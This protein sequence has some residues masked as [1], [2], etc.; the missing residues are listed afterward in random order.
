M[1]EQIEASHEAHERLRRIASQVP[2][3]LYQFLRRIDGSSC[4]PYCSEGIRDI[5]GVDPEDVIDDAQSAF[6]VIHLN[7][8]ERVNHSIEESA[9]RLTPWELEYRVRLPDSRERWVSGQAI[10]QRLEDGSTLWHGFITDVTERIE[11][12]RQMRLLSA[13]VDSAENT[14][15]ITDTR[16]RL[17]WANKAFTRLTGYGLDEAISSTDN[18]LYPVQQD[19]DFYRELWNTINRGQVW[20]GQLVNRRR[21]GS[22]Y[23]EHMTITPVR[24][25]E[26]CVANFIAVK[27]DVTKQN[28][29][30][31]ELNRLALHDGLTG[32]PNR[33]RFRNKL[34]QAIERVQ[35]EP[36]F[37]FTMLFFNLDRFKIIN[38]SL[39]HEAGDK[40]LIEMSR[41]LTGKLRNQ[42]IV[43]R[44]GGDEFAMLLH[45][46][47]DLSN[48]EA[49]ARRVVRDVA[50]PV[51][52]DGQMIS[53]SVSIG[54]VFIEDG[55]RNASQILRD[56][57]TAMYHAKSS[58]RHCV[59]TFDH[60]MRDEVVRRHFLENELRAE[61]WDEEF[62]LHYQ[63]V[64]G[65][66][67][68]CLEGFEALVR[69]T[70]AS[71]PPVSP[72]VFIPIAEE[73]GVI[74][75]LGDW[76]FRQACRQLRHWLDTT[77]EGMQLNMKVNFSRCQFGDPDLI[78][79]V[80][81]VLPEERV[82]PSFLTLE[83]TESVMLDERLDAAPIL[84][85]LRQLGVMIALDD[86]G[87]GYSSLSCLSNLP[88]DILKIDRS[89]V[90]DMSTNR[91]LIAIVQAIIALTDCLN[92]QVIA[93]GVESDDHVM[94]L[95]TLGCTYAQGYYFGRPSPTDQ[96][97]EYLRKMID[98]GNITRRAKLLSG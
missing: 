57:D 81:R 7:D 1:H 97:T 38:D 89:F 55:S 50:E 82:P 26:G 12:D 94:M 22:A 28:K 73:I 71:G 34:E 70:P 63:P 72:D 85:R 11:A 46:V 67:D 27:E 37:R 24:N 54:L 48:A 75:S 33:T 30:R 19:G 76:V 14:I 95:Q 90:M 83:V 32:L 23:D 58:G 86:F 36:G 88:I 59:R 25:E 44:F 40:L 84:E 16:G 64:I 69:W 49:L 4:I 52:I 17:Q 47:R 8:R 93:E 98:E 43:S 45:G 66:E 39:G 87:T 3:V 62:S 96:A 68:G 2:G 35:A 92:M 77:P 53:T 21:D 65:L 61:R 60:E 10:P 56:T 79:R 20:S 29:V 51:F 9:R 13:A 78:D 42:D 80:A 74:N 31:E 5:F 41:R 18:L 6:N 15:V 91:E